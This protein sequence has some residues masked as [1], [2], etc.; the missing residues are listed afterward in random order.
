MQTKEVAISDRRAERLDEAKR[1]MDGR[2]QDLSLIAVEETMML[3][4]TM[5]RATS[6]RGMRR[7]LP[8]LALACVLLAAACRTAA[9]APDFD[10]LYRDRAA[11]TMR[12]DVDV[13]IARLAPDWRVQLRTGKTMNRE[14]LRSRLQMIFEQFIVRQ[15]RYDFAV[16]K[17]ERIGDEYR[18]TYEQRDHRIQRAKDGGTS[19][20]EANVIHRDTWTQTTA[21]WQ[22]RLTEE[23][24]QTKYVV[25]GVARVLP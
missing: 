21:G 17:V 22:V 24:E 18:V 20:V 11:A 19:E 6:R 25:D 23:L 9:P 8:L 1:D 5:S 3:R 16:Q 15:V 14:E 4:L 13:L 2:Y 12:H 7:A 10:A